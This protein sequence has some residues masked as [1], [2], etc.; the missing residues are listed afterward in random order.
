MTQRL[1]V[2][3]HTAPQPL[4][5]TLKNFSIKAEDIPI[6]IRTYLDSSKLNTTYNDY[7]H[8]LEFLYNYRGSLD[9][10]E[11]YRREVERLLQWC[12]FIRRSSLTDLKRVDIEHFIEFCQA[13]PASWVG[14]NTYARFIN[15]N[16]E[17]K[18]NPNWRPFVIKLNKAS[19]TNETT[20]FV[21]SANALQAIFAILSSFFTYLV[22]EEYIDTNPISLLRQKSK[23]LRKYQHK[24]KVRRL[25]E[26]QWAYVVETAEQLAD[27]NP[28]RHERTLFIIKI[29]YSMYLRISELT[30]TERWTPQM[31]DFSMDMD[32][33]WWFTTVGKGNK[34][35]DITVSNDM[36]LVLKRYRGTLGL[37]ALPIP[38]EATPLINK[39]RG[40]GPITST[41]QIRNIV[42]YCF[43]AAIFNM[44]QDGFIQDAEQL[45]SAT[46]HWLRHTGI[47]DDVK[48]RPREHVRDDAGHG[49]SAITDKYIDVELRE[50][51]QSGRN[52]RITP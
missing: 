48:H 18:P 31:G 26:T 46:V 41:R 22:Q 7:Q 50:R 47:S 14:K 15:L 9:T 10:F 49:S 4:F 43:D 44:Q 52:K 1:A 11:S 42:K 34:E 6:V 24:T 5:D 20:A 35:R 21:L 38:G 19:T 3:K 32:G 39:T 16:G 33:N 12:W 45:K 25:T 29:L 27:E 17:R 8:S 36:L 30:A 13:P 37:L 28:S 40:I 2:S 23:Y 51:H